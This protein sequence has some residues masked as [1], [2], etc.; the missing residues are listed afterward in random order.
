MTVVQRRS[1]VL[2]Y[3]AERVRLSLNTVENLAHTNT[4]IELAKSVNLGT[5]HTRDPTG[6]YNYL[7]QMYLRAKPE[8]QKVKNKS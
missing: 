8:V 7:L 1:L 6:I 2:D 3:R 5:T 4:W